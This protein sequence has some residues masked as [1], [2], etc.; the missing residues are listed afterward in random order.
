MPAWKQFGS[1]EISDLISY[2]RSWQENRNNL[3]ETLKL[4]SAG[5]KNKHS[6][7]F[8][9]TLFDANCK[10]CHG[11][12][13]Q[14]D[15]GPSLSTPEFLTIVD[16]KYLYEAIAFGR[17][18][19]GMPAWK[20]FSNGDVAALINH[21]RAWQTGRQRVLAQ[22]YTSGDWQ[23]GRFL[24]NDM[25]SSCHGNYAEGSIGIQL[26]NP[27]FLQSSSNAMLQ[28]WI[29][30]GKTGTPMRG[31]G[32][33]SHGIA[34]LKDDQITDI[35]TYIRYLEDNSVPAL[36]ISPFGLPELGRLWY[37]SMCSSCHGDYGEGSS[38]PALSNSQFLQTA[39]D[40]F[41]MATLALGRDGTEM[42][43]VTKSPQSIHSL[44]TDKVNDIIAYI[45]SW[46]S[47]SPFTGIIN[48]L[49]A[50]A[51]IDKGQQLYES[52]CA[53]CH[54][55]NGLPDKALTKGTNT[56]LVVAPT[57]NNQEFLKSA[58]DGFIRA[59]VIRGRLGTAMRPF[60]Q[61][62]SGVTDLSED[63]INNIVAFIRNWAIQ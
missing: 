39:S 9:E 14:G 54:G 63:D 8:G 30:F 58:T 59:T 13:G 5:F 1:Q 48:K 19:A 28:E 35:I 55:I 44:S 50:P 52:N 56:G 16:N 27:E 43:P 11:D 36:R 41:L 6:S 49:S 4:V 18:A 42:R 51:D 15:L 23:I 62:F 20:H 45:R 25:C 47:S 31:F 22:K 7:S 3:K 32:K 21:I 29:A 46:A 26:K 37:V 10:S 53:G 33:G 34:E 61:G 17:T 57:L 24:Y 38:G 12:S 40:G 60:G 2:M